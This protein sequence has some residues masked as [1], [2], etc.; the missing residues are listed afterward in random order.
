[1]TSRPQ[2]RIAILGTFDVE[3][4]GDLLFPLIARNELTARLGAVDLVPFSYRAKSV[5]EWIYDVHSVSEFPSLVESFDAVLIGGGHLIRFDKLIAHG[6]LPP[7]PEIHHPTGYW[8]SPALAAIA[9]SVPT[10]WN[11]PSAS[12]GTPAWAR[13]LLRTALAESAYVSVRDESSRDELTLVSP[14][15]EVRVVPDTVFGLDRLPP[16]CPAGLIAPKSPYLVVHSHPTVKPLVDAIRRDPRFDA[17]HLV[18]I[19]IGPAIGDALGL[20]DPTSERESGLAGWDHPLDIASLVAGSEGV[21][22]RS[23]HL[24]VT[25]LVYGKAAI[26]PD[27]PEGSKY[28]W[29]GSSPRVFAGDSDE[30]RA[31]FAKACGTTTR[32]ELAIESS[33]RTAEHWDAIASIVSAPK[34]RRT[35][36][37]IMEH[38]FSIHS[39][40]ENAELLEDRCAAREAERD[41]A[42]DEAARLREVASEVERLRTSSERAH[43][44]IERLASELRAR[45]ITIE[46]IQVAERMSRFESSTKPG[47]S[48]LLGRGLRRAGRAF[49]VERVLASGLFDPAHVLRAHPEF[50]QVGAQLVRRYLDDGH[51]T[52]PG[53]GFDV[54]FYLDENPDVA[55]ATM[56]PL[57]HY[58]VFGVHEGRLPRS[59]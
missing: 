28:R 23:L 44:E 38:F 24:T 8:L 48:P 53:P 29:F 58:L 3:N 43:A 6:Y 9:A 12:L 50:E 10:I 42:R 17:F 14:E 45:E 36:R 51:R 2:P 56:H 37:R 46:R 39:D 1:M 57:I 34:E 5:G 32:C 41:E 35:S 49:D 13:P 7:S 26:V 55:A 25:G 52:D 27:L 11:A 16:H 22:A 30:T 19:P 54:T 31:A 33:R 59:V 21:V 47:R 4:Y 18:E 20:V 15:S 40:L